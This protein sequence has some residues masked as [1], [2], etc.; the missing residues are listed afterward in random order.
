SCGKTITRFSCPSGLRAAPSPLFIISCINTSCRNLAWHWCRTHTAPTKQ[1]EERQA[2]Y[3]T[4]PHHPEHVIIG[5][6]S[7]LVLHCARQQFEGTVLGH[8]RCEPTAGQ[9]P[10]EIVDRL[11]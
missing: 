7:G 11:R 6:H 5:H 2:E 1:E 10:R 8:A 9:A 4:Y 3:E